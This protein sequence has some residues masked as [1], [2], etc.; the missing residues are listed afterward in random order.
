MDAS[1][2]LSVQERCMKTRLILIITSCAALVLSGCALIGGSNGGTVSSR[3]QAAFQKVFMSSYYAERGGVP[4]GAKGLTPFLKVVPGN[5]GNGAKTT[6]PVDQLTDNHFATL[7]PKTLVNFPEPGE[8]TTF[9]V[10]M[11]DAANLVYDIV[12]TTTYPSDDIR[13]SYVEEYYVKDIAAGGGIGVWDYNDPIVK[14][15]GGWVQDQKARV[16]QV[17]TFTD[18]TTRTETIVA[19]T[20]QSNYPTPNYLKF[21]PFP[22][23]DPA[24]SPSDYTF[25]SAFYPNTPAHDGNIQFSSVVVYYV[26]PASNTNYWFWQGTQAETIL[27]VRYYTEDWNTGT[28]KFNSYTVSFEKT[29]D[30]LTTTGGSYSQTLQRVFAGSQFNTLAETVLRQ[31]VTY[32]LDGSGHL[33]LSTGQKLTYMQSRVADITGKKD[34]Y[35]QQSNSDYVSLNNWST[36]TIYTPTGAVSEVLAGNPSA[37]LYG[38]T[39]TSSIG[40]NLPLAVPST[41][42]DNTGTG[43]LAILYTSIQQGNGVNVTGSTIPGSIQPAG[44]EW[45]YTGSQGTN[46]PYSSSYDLST[47]GTIEAWV[48]INQQTD[49]GGIVHKGDLPDFSDEAWSLQFWGNQGQIAFVIDPTTATGSGGYALLTSTVNL[50]TGKWYYL[51]ATWDGTASTPY[52][53]L[54]INGTQNN[55]LPSPSL[56][57][58]TA[59]TNP[60][61]SVHVGSQLP[62]TYDATYGYFGFNGKI[63]GVRI[64][65]TP[66][67]ATTVAANYATYILQ[68][69]NW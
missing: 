15:S 52:M 62:T 35:L 57:S 61:S 64:S 10:T 26:T 47:K 33:I 24:S 23:T 4:G 5:K 58:I 3:D 66:M 8:T 16:Q 60:P 68:T 50:N 42:S 41:Q 54:Y 25:N 29:I 51:V 56:A 65:A 44:V 12:A 9:T 28:S 69:P 53:Y 46:I 37:F 19:Q 7:S 39:A 55:S 20:D 32:D 63:N 30:T 1:N 2:A 31:Q 21:D 49:T 45:T 27:G 40:G 17:L 18:G 6:V 48:Y 59:R 38:R 67:S 11:Q 13:K 43:D 22:V 14:Q 36:T 34:F